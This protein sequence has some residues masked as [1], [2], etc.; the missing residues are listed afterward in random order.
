MSGVRIDIGEW[1]VRSYRLEDL[2]SLVR[3]ANDR[4]VSANLTDQF[5][6]PYTE[7][8]GRAWLRIVADQDPETSF[9]IG[10]DDGVI[11]GIGL[12][13][14][15]DVYRVGGEIGYWLGK[16]F[17]GRGIVTAAVRA[18]TDYAFETFG[19]S[20]IYAGVYE[21]NPASVRVLQ[22]AGY[23]FEGRLRRAVIKNGRIMDLMLYAIT[24]EDTG[25]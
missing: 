6:Y 15:K 13:L 2:E 24:D 23:T 9:A 1:Q 19:L 21:S 7:D 10:D 20:R 22:K 16:Q 5:P 18:V 8:D 12:E 4:D 14:K 17:W 25:R 11:G 3:H